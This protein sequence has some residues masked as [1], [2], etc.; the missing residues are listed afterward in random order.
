MLQKRWST[1]TWTLQ[2]KSRPEEIRGGLPMPCREIW[3]T[4][5]WGADQAPRP[6]RAREKPGWQWQRKKAQ[7]QRHWS[8]IRKLPPNPALLQPCHTLCSIRED[9]LPHSGPL[10]AA[11]KQQ[12]DLRCHFVLLH[13]TQMSQFYNWPTT[14]GTSWHPQ[15]PELQAPWALPLLISS[16]ATAMLA[17]AMLMSPY[18]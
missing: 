3:R 11:T 6:R 15:A 7:R 16:L 10:P 13:L 14:A 1:T 8:T 5:I 9:K 2:A 18:R 12:P 17:A 4:A